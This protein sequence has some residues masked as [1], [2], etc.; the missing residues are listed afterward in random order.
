MLIREAL[1]THF[2]LVKDKCDAELLP[3]IN[4]LNSDLQQE[5]LLSN[6]FL[7][8][9]IFT[10]CEILFETRYRHRHTHTAQDAIICHKGH[11]RKLII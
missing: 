1:H 11:T 4:K 7:F 2:I 6:V 3:S 8:S 5:L 9:R 10:E